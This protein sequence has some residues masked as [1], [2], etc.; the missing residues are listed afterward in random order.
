LVVEVEHPRFGTVLRAAPPV[1]F[2]E[3]PGR[4]APSCLLGEH[5]EAILAELGYSPEQIADLETRKVVFGT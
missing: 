4:V 2:S 1:S 5:T 3:T